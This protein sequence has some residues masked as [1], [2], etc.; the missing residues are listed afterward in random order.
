MTGRHHHPIPAD[1][2]RDALDEL[3]HRHHTWMLRTVRH[4]SI[5]EQDA[6]AVVQDVWLDVM[7]GA[8]SY[9]GD[10]S[11]RSWLETIVRRRITTTWR[12]RSARPQTLVDAVPEDSAIHG[13][14]EED[15]VLRQQLHGLLAELPDEQRDAIWLVD[16]R[17]LPIADAAHRLGI[18]AGTV[19]SRCFRG[20]ATLRRLIT[21]RA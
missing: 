6:E 10:G 13:G 18:P 4:L 19:K 5:G 1:Q 16:V 11:V 9:R 14:L 12:A 20:R 8:R 17:G 2:L 7:R 21:S 3:V 15:V